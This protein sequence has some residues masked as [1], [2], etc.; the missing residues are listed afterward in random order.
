M[1]RMPPAWLGGLGHTLPILIM[2][3]LTLLYARVRRAS[4]PRGTEVLLLLA[5]LLALRCALDPWDNSYY[6]LGWMLAIIA[7]EA[8]THDRPP[9]LSLTATLAAWFSLR[10][11]SGFGLGLPTD[12]EALIFLM[13]CLPGVT[14]LTAAVYAPGLGGRF[15]GRSRRPSLAPAPVTG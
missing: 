10:A 7:W 9:V 6:S 4:Q 5:L 11:T 14:A 2:P 12:T 1:L 3:P 13:L 15:V 8:L